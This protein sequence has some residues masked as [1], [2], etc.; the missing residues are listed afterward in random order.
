MKGSKRSDRELAKVL[1]VSQPT[2]TRMRRKLEENAI[3]EYT[4]I[5]NWDALGFELMAVTFVDM[6]G[7]SQSK[8]T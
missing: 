3:A 8:E 4:I 7:V 6:R 2:I 1:R 5:P